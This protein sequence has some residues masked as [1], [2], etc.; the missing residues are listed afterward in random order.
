MSW[1]SAR[2]L[3]HFLKPGQLDIE[4]VD[5]Q[6]GSGYVQV[7]DLEL[8]NDPSGNNSLIHGLPI[9]LHDGS[10]GKVTARIPWPNPL[11]STI[12][13]SLE[14]LHLTFY[15]TPTVVSSPTTAHLAESVASLSP[16]SIDNLPGGLDPFV[17]DEE[18]AHVEID[19]P[20][21][22]LFAT[23]I[24]RLLARFEFD[25]VD[26]KITLVHPQHSSFTLVIPNLRYGTELKESSSSSPTSASVP[27]GKSKEVHGEVRTVTISGVA[28]TT[29]CLHPPRTEVL[30]PVT[31]SSISRNSPSLR[32]PHLSSVT[33]P[34]S[35]P[36][37][38][39]YS[40]SSDLDEDTQ[41]L[42]SQSI[43]GLPPRPPSPASTVASSLYESAISTAY[44]VA[45]VE[46]NTQ[47]EPRLDPHPV[48]L[49]NDSPP[50]AQ[51]SPEAPFQ[52]PLRVT[53]DDPADETIVS[54][55][56]EPIVIRLT[57]PP[58]PRQD[59]APSPEVVLTPEVPRP[60]QKRHPKTT[61][62]GS[63]RRLLDE[64]VRLRMTMGVIACGFR[65]R[66]IRNILDIVQ[67]WS[68]HH[69]TRSPAQPVESPQSGTSVAGSS[70]LDEFE[71]SFHIR[72]IMLLLLPA[73]PHGFI[74]I[75]LDD[76]PHP[77]LCLPHYHLDLS[78]LQQKGHFSSSS[79]PAPNA[80]LTHSPSS[81]IPSPYHDPQLSSQYA[82]PHV[83]PDLSTID[84]NRSSLPVIE[85][86]DWTDMARFN[87]T[88][89]VSLWRTRPPPHVQLSS[90]A[91]A[92]SPFVG[93]RSP[94]SAQGSPR[95]MG[96]EPLVVPSSTSPRGVF[97]SSP[98]GRSVPAGSSGSPGK[99]NEATH[100]P[101]IPAYALGTGERDGKSAALAFL[102][103]VTTSEVPGP[104]DIARE[105]AFDDDADDAEEESEQ[106]T[107]DGETPP[108]T[109]RAGRFG[110]REQERERE[111]ERRRL[112]RL[113]LE[114]LD[115]GFDYRQTTPKKTASQTA[116]RVRAW[117][118]R[119]A[120]VVKDPTPLITVVFPMIRVQIRCVPP[121][122]LS[123]RSGAVVLDVHDL[124]LRSSGDL[125]E[126]SGASTRFAVDD[127]YTNDP[128]YPRDGTGN[129][130]MSVDWRR[131][132]VAYA[133]L[134]ESKAHAILSVGSMLS[135]ESTREDVLFG[136]GTSPP[137]L[138]VGTPAR[139]PFKPI[140][141]GIQ[142]WADDLTQLMEAVARGSD[143]WD[144]D[145]ERAD[146]TDT[147][148]IGSRFFAKS[149]RLGS[150]ASGTESGSTSYASGRDKMPRTRH[151]K[152]EYVASAVVRLLVPRQEENNAADE[153]VLTLG[154]MDLTVNE[155]SKSGAVTPFL[156]LTTPY[157]LV[158]LH[159]RSVVKLRFTS[160]VVPETT[161][162]ESR[163]KA[164]EQVVPS[165]RTR[166][167][168]KI[169]D[170]SIRALAPSH[171]GALVSYIG[172]LDFSTVI[173][174]N[175]P[176]S[177][178]HLNVTAL[179]LLLID[180]LKAIGVPTRKVSPGSNMLGAAFWRDAGYALLA[181]L[182][183]F[184]MRFERD[185]SVSP[186]D[187][188]VTI[189]RADL[190]LHFCADT[191]TA[192]GSFISDLTSAFSPPHNPI[193]LRPA[194]TKRRREPTNVSDVSQSSRGLLSSLDE[195]AFRQ[196]PEVGSA[197]DMIIDDLPTNPDYL[198]ESFGTAAGLRE[199]TD[200]DLDDF[201]DNTYE[202]SSPGESE[203]PG[204]SRY[205][206]ET[207]RMLRPEG[208][209][210][211][212]NYFKTITPESSDEA[213]SFGETVLR[214]RAHNF[215]ATLFLYGGYDWAR[216]RRIIEEERKDMRR[217]L[218]KI[219]QLVASG[220]TPDPSVEETSTLLFN[221]VYIGLEHNVDE[222]EP[223][224]LI[225]AI[226]E[227][228]NEDLETASQ[229]S[230][231]SLKP[232][233]TSPG[234]SGTQ[235]QRSH[236][237]RMNR[238]RGPSIEFRLLGLN[239][240]VDNYRPE[241]SLVS[242]T[243]V[244]IKDL[245]ILD[246]IKTSTWRKFLTA[247]EKDSRGNVRESDS[248]M[249]RVELRSVHPVE[250]HSSEEARLRAKILPLRLHVDQDA[251][252]FLKKFFSFK[253]P[254][255]VPANN[256]EPADEIYFQQAE[257]FPVDL[258]LDYKPRRVDYRALREGRTI[259]L[260][261]FFHFDGAEMTLRHIT[262]TGITGWSRFFDLLNDLWTPDVK[263]TQLVDVIS[264]VAPIRSVVN[265]GSG[266]ADL[267]LLP[268]AQYKKDGRVVRG[269]QKG[270]T[271]FV[272]SAGIEAIKLGARLA[273][274]TQV[275]LEQAEH[276]LGGQFRDQVTA[277]ALQS[278]PT[279]HALGE[280]GEDDDVVDLI[281]RYADQPVNVKEGV[282]SA[283]KSLRKNFNSAAQT[284]LAV[285]MEVYERSGNEGPV[286]AV[287]RAV[288]IAVLKPMIGASEAVS[289]TL[290]G[291][292]NSLDPNIRYENEAKYKQR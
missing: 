23:L 252:D 274:G 52:R 254:D 155:T 211:I 141:D 140:L 179:S 145:T 110:I 283:Y 19:P 183:D 112:E 150:Q 53:M 39:P 44:A 292:H 123:P 37:S 255:S 154:V 26:T 45:P 144:L 223:T 2:S 89:K 244:T 97:S 267:V 185:E 204:Y 131:L 109:P 70:I 250:G 95:R 49:N 7:R 175:S 47:T 290:L 17:T 192:L 265:V 98:P 9:Q 224:A 54:F 113:V 205:G 162:K 260:M 137:S 31:P 86:V 81:R 238:A 166:I 158:H 195:H 173:V 266:V 122:L 279:M 32:R 82:L 253:D 165:E 100:R 136:A 226:D 4:Q 138:V 25:A 128:H 262:L 56:S 273:T 36:P 281:S 152:T 219:R 232:Q 269:L 121:P 13:F 34:G 104:R 79:L 167:T 176:Q 51:M 206:G 38:S 73:L 168:V 91:R 169:M 58:I 108:G 15:V 71:A 264:G 148:L 94:P 157:S 50:L 55:V 258:K 278:S 289:K 245:E 182:S 85:V 256:T 164:F 212:E 147:S 76:Y 66:H 170:T 156:C 241:A 107:E 130:L 139:P 43:A 187:T 268:I 246:H 93:G 161:A 191:L 200:D 111:R 8:D 63:E 171:S 134:G 65:A 22:S 218:A 6:I 46:H 214:V 172:E 67:L 188:R 160:L 221:S 35:P 92:S 74:R 237:K 149:R 189:G 174:G 12:G 68:S 83:H 57:T 105:A 132:V 77:F 69:P 33:P 217:R 275:I 96:Q 64:K 248:N 270:T 78:Y 29:R 181:E 257:V 198:D 180:D 118:K 199:M 135:E 251:L 129:T 247:I 229:S 102:E 103:E 225:A 272:K 153:T 243:L 143:A 235:S 40:D 287:V 210:I 80:T 234:K 207:I 222:L 202:V 90:H 28:V 208:L 84:H 186:A 24:E 42:M 284:I 126:S 230:W 163:I 16:L 10:L 194:A 159:P 280:H 146:S 220:Q 242:R 178:F 228:L 125:E 261:N 62:R 271:S 184:D 88:D 288:P 124:R 227:E 119:Q 216:T 30:S 20:G 75:H 285:P 99:S 203:Q 1:W 249:A 48:G 18:V 213:S 72:G 127:P 190:R 151:L 115:L 276:V 120:K 5:S 196:L 240:E 101:H 59:P 282:Q 21:V 61:D 27:E 291:L 133:I 3:G 60:A 87:A 193:F 236:R 116:S 215:N 277:E 233:P 117:N 14:S 114:D 239:A 259:E 286:R 11:T 201:E 106:D 197:P 41:M 209:R 177:S 142:L 231:Q 263:A